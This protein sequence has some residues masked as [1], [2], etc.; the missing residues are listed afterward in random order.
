M[1][2]LSSF[3]PTEAVQVWSMRVSPKRESFG[4]MVSNFEISAL[5]PN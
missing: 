3:T 2:R 4:V 5:D 1:M